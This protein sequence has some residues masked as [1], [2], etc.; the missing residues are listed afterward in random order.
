M[1]CGDTLKG[2]VCVARKFLPALM[3]LL[4]PQYALAQGNCI[5]PVPPPPVDGADATP[6]Q[7]RAAIA[8]AREF[9][10][11]ANLYENCLRQELDDTKARDGDGQ[12]VNV[13]LDRETR[14]RI[15]A[16][17]RLKDKVSSEAAGAIDA[18]KKAHPD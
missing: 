3:L 18:Y 15:A 14:V 13:A 7:L 12:T 16:N 5:A 8:H 9:I 2:I 11:Q 10:G 17:R 4:T 1:N 6:E